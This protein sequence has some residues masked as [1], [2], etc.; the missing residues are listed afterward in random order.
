MLEEKAID[1][2][3]AQELFRSI[4]QSGGGVFCRKCCLSEGSTESDTSSDSDNSDDD[5]DEVTIRPSFVNTSPPKTTYLHEYEADNSFEKEWPRQ[6]VVADPIES[7]RPPE[8]APLHRQVF[9]RLY[10]YFPG[11]RLPA[12]DENLPKGGIQKPYTPTPTAVVP[13]VTKQNSAVES[14]KVHDPYECS[15]PGSFPGYPSSEIPQYQ[16]A[17]ST[18]TPQD[19]E[20]KENF[21]DDQRPPP[22][23]ESPTDIILEVPTPATE[24]IQMSIDNPVSSMSD[25]FQD[26]IPIEDCLFNPGPNGFITQIRGPSDVSFSTLQTLLA[27]PSRRL[28]RARSDENLQIQQKTNALLSIT[29]D[30]YEDTP[31]E[32]RSRRFSDGGG[33]EFTSHVSRENDV[34]ELRKWKSELENLANPPDQTTQSQNLRVIPNKKKPATTEDFTLNYIHQ[35][36]QVY[37]AEALLDP[38][39]PTSPVERS[40]IISKSATPRATNPLPQSRLFPE[41]PKS[42]PLKAWFTQARSPE[43]QKTSGPPRL[44]GETLRIHNNE[45]PPLKKKSHPTFKIETA[46]VFMQQVYNDTA[47]SVATSVM[48]TRTRKSM[49]L[50]GLMLPLQDR[51]S[52][53]LERY[54]KAGKADAVRMLLR[55]GCNPG[56]IKEP[57][58]D[59]IFYVVR[60]AS[61]RHTKCLRSLIDHKVHVNVRAKLTRKT[62]LIEAV[63][64]EAW[65]GYVT[66]IFL[67]LAA[68]AN[69]NAK[70]GAGDVA[71]LKLLGAGLKPLQEHRRKAL[72]LLLSTSYNTNINVTPLGTGNNPLHLAIRRVDPWALSM[73][74]EKDNSLIEAKNSE[75]LTPLSHACSAWT[76]TITSGQLEIL[77]VL[78]EKKANVNVNTTAGAKTP[79]HTAVSLGLVDAV[80]RLLVN[81]ADPL[82]K[83]KDGKTAQDMAEERKNQ[84][85]CNDCADCTE[86]QFLLVRHIPKSSKNDEG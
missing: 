28:P 14:S 8:R 63:E 31:S 7:T 54:T 46:S 64:Q 34:D 72:A 12:K 59:P 39:R 62:P 42:N 36:S 82:R 11:I 43:I 74:L 79:L 50:Y 30:G 69:P 52:H 70:D 73:L 38:N 33:D 77:D 27:Q 53:F 56:T 21:A 61:S 9:K 6:S 75:G 23:N 20:S 47:S 40:N 4:K 18:D 71:L 25:V 15:L 32:S 57:R 1:R 5:R 24:D 65:S 41:R 76:S 81:G 49:K 45:V 51:S 19:L 58:P 55:E 37:E 48:S 16:V 13:P 60:G 86:I 2:P 44:T 78:L 22:E 26:T 10:S 66:V 67:L 17:E 3:T 85:D 68:G 29:D 83:T 80:E 84:H 35:T